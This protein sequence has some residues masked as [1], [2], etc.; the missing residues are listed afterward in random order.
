MLAA[1]A[2]RISALGP[3][4]RLTLE[5]VQAVEARGGRKR[6]IAFAREH[7]DLMVKAFTV[8]MT[9][10]LRGARLVT[11]LNRVTALWP[12]NQ[13]KLKKL[14]RELHRALTRIEQGLVQMEA[15]NG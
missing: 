9:D 11:E 10:A 1:I 4:Y 8:L 3:R 13:R 14:R 15:D 6:A 12:P 2:E 7:D 5:T